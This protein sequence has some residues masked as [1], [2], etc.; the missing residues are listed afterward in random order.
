MEILDVFRFLV[1]VEAGLIEGLTIAIWK[2]Y[3]RRWRIATRSGIGGRRSSDTPWVGLLPAH[4]WLVSLGTFIL[5]A[6][7]AAH[8]V[9]RLGEPDFLWWLSPSAFAGFSILLL[10]LWNLLRYEFRLISR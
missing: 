9:I 4:V 5:V 6:G 10:A 7:Y 8:I 1:L 3:H 2:V